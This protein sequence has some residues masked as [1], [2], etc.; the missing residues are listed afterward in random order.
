MKTITVQQPV[1]DSKNEVLLSEQQKQ[2]DTMR[3]GIAEDVQ[4]IRESVQN[5]ISDALAKRGRGDPSGSETENK[6]NKAE[7]E[8]LEKQ[9]KQIEETYKA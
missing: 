5:M 6:S 1:S 8:R 7:R 2:L 3:S 9:V 4:R